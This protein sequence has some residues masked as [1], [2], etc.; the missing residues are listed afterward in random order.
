MKCIWYCCTLLAITA[1]PGCI[2]SH[3]SPAVVSYAPAFEPAPPPTSDRPAPRVYAVPDS[4]NA[5]VAPPSDPPPG[6]SAKDL[7]TAD[8]IS[9]LLKS[10][11]LL[12]NISSNVQT[13]VENGIVTLQGTVPSEQARDELALR[14]WKVP[15]VVQI[16]NELAVSYR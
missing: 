4:Q 15:G 3:H 7:A 12:A 11:P 2:Q 5:V 9:H 16:K 8:S 6:V 13:T 1:G 10:D 14:L